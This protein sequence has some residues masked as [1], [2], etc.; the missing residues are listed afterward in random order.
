MSQSDEGPFALRVA[1]R[2]IVGLLRDKTIHRL[3]SPVVVSVV[4]LGGCA[5]RSSPSTQGSD[6]LPISTGDRELARSALEELYPPLPL[7]APATQPSTPAPLESIELYAQARRALLDNSRFTAIN[8]LERAIKLDPDSFEPRYLLGQAYL[9]SNISND[10]SL[11]ILESAVPLRPDHLDLRTL[12]G[13][14]HLAKNELDRAIE[15]LVTAS[16]TSEYLHDDDSAAVVDYYLARALQLKGYDVAALDRYEILQGRLRSPSI[17]IRA[18]SELN[19]LVN[20]P[21]LLYLLIGELHE[22]TGTPAEALRLY[23]LAADRDRSNFEI[24]AKLI[25]PMIALG[26]ADDAKKHVS[27]LVARFRAS[28]ESLDLL[29]DTYRRLG[30][31]AEV[32]RELRKL[33]EQNPE[34]R[35]ILFSYT[36]L[37]RSEGKRDEARASL[38]AAMTTRPGDVEVLRRLADLYFDVDDTAGAARLF[39]E[40][41]A[42][43]PDLLREVQPMWQ[44]VIEPGRKNRLR[45]AD[46]QKLEV[47]ESAEA[48]KHYMVARLADIWNRDLLARSS[49]E[50]A[51]D[52]ATPFPP[53][54]R[55]LLAVMLIRPDWDEKQKDL[56]AK[57]L[58]ARAE[59]AGQTSLATEL[60]GTTLVWKG[61]SE[62]AAEELKRSFDAGSGDPE[63]VLA[64]ASALLQT[65]RASQA[66]KVLWKLVSDR[67]TFD[68]AYTSLFGYYLRAGDGVQAEK[69]L[70]AWLA[71]D[72]ASIEARALQSS[73]LIR[74]RRFPAAQRVIDG[75]FA[76][77]PNSLDVLMTMR[78][79]YAQTGRQAELVSRLQAEVDQRPQNRSAVM[80]LVELL[81]GADRAAEAS[82]IIDSARTAA[83]NDADVLYDLAHLYTRIGQ[84]QMT[85]QVLEQVLKIDPQHAPANN[86]LGYQWADDGRQLDRAEGMIRVAVDAEPDNQSFLDSLGW[87][88]YKRSKFAEARGYLESAIG[89]AAR[90]DPIVLDHLG[91]TLYRMSL[92]KEAD[93]QWRRAFSRLSELNTDREE[94]RTLRI[95]LVNKLRAMEK[96]QAVEVAP[97]VEETPAAK[98]GKAE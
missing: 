58:A 75:M 49:L 25:G 3:L 26:R 42:A 62:L 11:E 21:E 41:I 97:V 84:R 50:K 63:L 71:A 15:H 88:L 83:G 23:Q 89:S 39:I 17:T 53:A 47:T 96:G 4:L 73:L 19:Y 48:A 6:R 30:L 40:S 35:S 91:D 10:R 70:A 20:R 44:Q 82:R 64:Y 98:V 61:E 34:D 16:R 92:P 33:H 57:S 55:A 93:A 14:Q 79:L 78:L 18:N 8:L 69:V 86:D 29:R 52:H 51:I 67:P 59:L 1:R 85:E 36:D 87:V 94:L 27:Q 54:Y 68:E 56:F 72:P 60:R 65:G 22:K 43:K 81:A 32:A 28:G 45:I 38:A 90:P 46:L 7:P 12:L 74:A 13:R 2:I 5:K 80:M 24:Q 95:Q 37:L 31:E 77:R 76:D 66:E 9:G